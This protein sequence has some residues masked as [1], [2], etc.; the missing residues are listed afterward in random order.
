MTRTHHERM[1]AA[2]R[3]AKAHNVP[4]W[5]LFRAGLAGHIELVLLWHPEQ[6]WPAVEI[7][8][9]R[10]KPTVVLVCD[11]P[12][13]TRPPVGPT[14][15]AAAPSLKGWPSAALVNGSGPARWQ[16]DMA[17]AGAQVVYK[18]ALVETASQFAKPWARFLDAP[19]IVVVPPGQGVHP[20]A[21]QGASA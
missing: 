18:V 16:Y 12:H 11:D 5:P 7:A 10:G 17:L 21:S 13:P 9:V 19:A 2:A 20:H 8:R 1:A 3:Y 4:S 15:W 6:P 14:G